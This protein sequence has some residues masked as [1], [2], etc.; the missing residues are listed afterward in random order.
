MAKKK[1]TSQESSVSSELIIPDE[2]QPKAAFETIANLIVIV[3]PE[4]SPNKEIHFGMVN[5]WIN[6]VTIG[7]DKGSDKG[8]QLEIREEDIK[9]EATLESYKTLRSVAFNAYVDMFTKM[10]DNE[11]YGSL[12]FQLDIFKLSVA[13]VDQAEELYR[14]YYGLKPMELPDKAVWKRECV[15]HLY[16]VHKYWN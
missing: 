13:I 16:V 1:V 14:L 11:K 9:D 4:H 12:D 7:F 15:P 6:D 10:R 2:M 8:K 5:V 3:N